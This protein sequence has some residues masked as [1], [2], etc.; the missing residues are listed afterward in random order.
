MW[1]EQFGDVPGSYSVYKL[2]D[3]SYASTFW[4]QSQRIKRKGPPWYNGSNIM[5]LI[6]IGLDGIFRTTH[7]SSKFFIHAA[8]VL[9]SGVCISLLGMTELLEAWCLDRNWAVPSTVSHEAD[10]L[11]WLFWDW[12]HDLLAHFGVASTANDTNEE[13][14]RLFAGCV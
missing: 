11:F 9:S 2:D 13:N 3:L 5:V 6:I 12:G 8:Y 7:S 10:Q 4:E 1:L 14:P